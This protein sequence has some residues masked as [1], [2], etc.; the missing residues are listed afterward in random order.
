VEGEGWAVINSPPSSGAW[1]CDAPKNALAETMTTTG[2]I[3]FIY[4]CFSFPNLAH[5]MQEAGVTW[6]FYAPS[7]SESGY[8]WSTLDAFSDIRNSELWKTNVVSYSQFTKDALKGNLP[9]VSWLVTTN[10]ASEHPSASSCAGE[11]WSV[12]QINAIMKGPDWNSTAIFLVWDDFGGFYDHVPPPV[13]DTYGLG[14]RVPML[15]ISPYVVSGTIAHTQYE[16]SSILKFIEDNWGLPPMS[17]HD[18]NANDPWNPSCAAGQCV[19]NFNQNPLPPVILKERKCPAPGPVAILR[20]Y[21][22]PFGYVNVGSKVMKP[23]TLS[24][25]GTATLENIVIE[26]THG[27]F[28]QTNNCPSSLQRGAKCRIEVTFAPTEKE[29]S[30]AQVIIS[31]ND[32]AQPQYAVVNGTGQ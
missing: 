18:R 17:E 1:G 30:A 20:P 22:M 5:E 19:F 11:N 31:D 29:R 13:V 14:I 7:K 28:T 2:K 24:N 3:G 27:P 21:I 23:I 26:L 9:E 6:K 16:L 10:G 12:E 4:P 32:T 15:V 25:Q 8:V